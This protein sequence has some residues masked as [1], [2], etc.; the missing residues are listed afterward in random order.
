MFVVTVIP[1]SR[2][3]F[4]EHLTFF[5][6]EPIAAG[7]VV[8]APVRGK[9]TPALVVSSEEA[10]EAR[11]VL[12]GSKFALKKIA[13]RSKRRLLPKQTVAALADSATYHALPL[14]IVLAQYVP[15]AILN[16]ENWRVSEA[17]ESER[18]RDVAS[19]ILALQA[20]FEERVRMYRS[21]AREAFARGE[22]VVIIAPSIAEAENLEQLLR[23]GIEEQVLVITG[24]TTKKGLRT[25]WNR[26]VDDAAPLLIIAT[27]PYLA[28]P[29]A[30]VG[31]YIVERESARSYL[32]PERPHL[33][34]RV[35][36]EAL[37]KRRGARLIYADFPLRV[38]T[39]A[40]LNHGGIEELTRLQITAQSSVRV[41]LID[42]RQKAPAAGAAGAMENRHPEKKK[43]S[44]FTKA[45]EA[46]VRAEIARG[47]RV[48]LY[49]SRKGLAPLTVCNDCG[50]PI[51]DPSGGTPMTLH[52][53]GAGNVFLSYR[54][55]A[56]MPANISCA[57]C[58]SWNLVS[59]GIGIERVIDEAH[60]LF[61]GTPLFA[62]TAD[63]A[64][65]HAKAKKIQQ[66]F[67]N[68]PGAILAG[69]DRALPYLTEPVELSVVASIDSLLSISAWRAHEHALDT[70]FFL[71]DHTTGELVIQT[72]RTD[73][74]VMRAIATGNPTD[75][76]RAEIAEREQ[77]GY[78]PFA[79]FIGLSWSGTEKAAEHTARLV[80]NALTG[81]DVVGPLP[82]LEAPRGRF[83]ARAV[84]RLEA[85]RWV[86]P[87][88]LA[89]LRTLPPGVAVS[90][91][92]D[93]IV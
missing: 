1:I 42:A 38:E 54:S 2:G 33:D 92:P 16:A 77:F 64:P 30:H 34:A 72:R 40:R 39:H 29:R 87:L 17:P 63:S 71:I 93:E 11:S 59:L 53:T 65:T 32:R 69:T 28:V 61:A 81:F 19:D 84:V 47:G 50:T 67:F 66:H 52:K 73:S 91:D 12:R 9:S 85:G 79:T 36:L 18:E 23:R 49:A 57:S 51:T 27:P 80:K 74:E 25:A 35:T 55:G 6:K 44:V 15:S 48:F 78:P 5:S 3:A 21:V 58:E 41:R 56:V 43:F 88:L 76:L 68:T 45:A 22:S 83:S 75:F 13:A 4:K 62:L 7:A 82:A 60:E 24:G 8:D 46:A 14:G 26:A 31:A 70:L 37:A 90:I 20:G 89:A 10:R 86:D